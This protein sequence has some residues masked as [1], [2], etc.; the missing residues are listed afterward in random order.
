M[1]DRFKKHTLLEI[2][3]DDLSE[4]A[5]PESI[6][7][8]YLS[9]HDNLN[10]FYANEMSFIF[11]GFVLELC[12]GG[13]REVTINGRRH[14]MVPGSILLLPPNQLM[15]IGRSS[16]DFERKSVMV[17]LDMILE[18]PSP[19]DIDIINAARTIPIICVPESKMKL[20]LEYYRFIEERYDAVGNIY[21]TEISKSLFYAMMLEICGIYKSVSGD[22]GGVP[23][24]KQESL[25][26]EF[27]LLLSANYKRHRTVTFY[28]G[29][30][31]LTP[32]YLSAA[33]KRISG[34]SVPE[35]INEAVII[36]IKRLLKTTD[37]TV[38]QISEHLNFSSPSAF[39]QFFR[40][41]VGI[42]PRSYRVGA[43]DVPPEHPPRV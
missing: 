43:S 31:N 42:T 28:A 17:S 32:K 21:R 3:T 33:V 9:I 11:D 18:F 5:G 26:D 30:M 2:D 13:W 38:L 39:V 41:N 19:V 14:E 20:L 12:Y 35:W 8:F 16:D 7:D 37:M 34:K 24:L 10:D 15:E 29:R 6:K 40:A 4:L 36:E 1:T 25:C 22:D 23:K 27:F